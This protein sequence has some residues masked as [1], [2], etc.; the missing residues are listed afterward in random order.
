MYLLDIRA[1]N[2]INVNIDVF[3]LLDSHQCVFNKNVN[4][5]G[6]KTLLLELLKRHNVYMTC[7]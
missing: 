7:G 4:S 5:A 2:S 3:R 6:F 1:D